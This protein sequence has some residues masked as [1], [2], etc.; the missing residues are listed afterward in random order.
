MYVLMVLL[1]TLI[2]QPPDTTALSAHNQ[3][4]YS[5][6]MAAA[7]AAVRRILTEVFEVMS[8]QIL[9]AFIMN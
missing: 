8:H 5:Y 6:T 1:N 7:T 3:Y 4:S 2:K 9:Y